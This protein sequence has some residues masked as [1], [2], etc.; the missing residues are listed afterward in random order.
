MLEALK[1]Q[2]ADAR[3]DA[4]ERLIDR[5]WSDERFRKSRQVFCYVSLPEEPD[6]HR[7]VRRL[8]DEGRNVAV[9]RV[10]GGR[11][12]PRA[13][14]KWD[15]SFRL[16]PFGI[17]EPDP[18]VTHP[19]E[20]GAIDCV[21]VPGLAFD[22]D[23]YRLGRGAGYYDKFLASIGPGAARIVA[24]FACQRVDRVPREPHDQRVDTVFFE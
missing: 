19:I 23:G 4:S 16:G 2:S 14:E 10:S 11:I 5:V 13:L 17:L 18:N 1:A 3:R 24:A 15:G 7:I 9:P 6:T 8:L 12:E 20:P 21:I 22:E